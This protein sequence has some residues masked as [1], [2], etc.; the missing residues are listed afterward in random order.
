MR[1]VRGEEQHG[2]SRATLNDVASAA[3]VSRQTVSNVLNAPQRVAPATLDR[4]RQEIVRLDFRPN[5]AARA[6]RRRRAEAL[7]LQ[8]SPPDGG[9]G[10]VLTSFLF[11]LT[12]AA[13]ACDTHVVTFSAAVPDDPTPEYEHLLGVRAVD[14]FLLTDTRHD[15]PRP[16]WLTARGVPFA[17]FGRVWDEP[18]VTSWVDVDGFA[19]VAAAV[20][21]LVGQGYG[22]V[23]FL[24]WP[25]GSPV[26]D[27]RR[28]GWRAA[29][30]ELGLAGAAPE[31]SSPQDVHAAAL[32][33]ATLLPRL[34]ERGALVCASDTLALGAWTLLRERGLRPGLDVGLV[35]VDDSAIART[36][37]ITSLR[38]PLP[39]IARTMLGL[40]AEDAPR[41]PEAAGVLLPPTVV[42]R[43]S[44]RRSPAHAAPVHPA[45][46][47]PVPAPHHTPGGP[48]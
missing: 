39:E 36:F 12:V 45:P 2:A 17:C 23:G 4:V 35:G 47:H 3:G 48:A 7:G 24:G 1:A 41:G 44:T 18:A 38:Q 16:Q 46:V 20:R 43:A 11:E 14:G 25:E 21:H 5:T 33:A 19:G 27:D 26:G 6:L 8:V 32:A 15:D 28:A 42:E 9:L 10:D 29:T 34:G 37:D 13:R 40:L 22:S 30:A 31:A